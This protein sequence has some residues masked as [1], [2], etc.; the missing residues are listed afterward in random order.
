MKA[1]LTVSEDPLL[2]C[3]F[4]D[5]ESEENYQRPEEEGMVQHPM[6]WCEECGARSVLDL[7]LSKEMSEGEHQIDLCKILKVVNGELCYFVVN[8]EVTQDQIIE[9]ID[10]AYDDSELFLKAPKVYINDVNDVDF[11]VGL[12]CNTYNVDEPVTPYPKFFDIDHDEDSYIF[13][14]CQRPNGEI[15]KTCY[16]GY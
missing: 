13:L 11:K 7:D 4:C 16:W 15:L 10:S 14:E 2:K 12:E 1:I 3:P 9:F 5:Y 8:R 6:L